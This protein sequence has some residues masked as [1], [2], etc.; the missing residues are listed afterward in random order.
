MW[1]SIARF[2][3]ALF[4]L[5][6]LTF[7]VAQAG[8]GKK[9]PEPNTESSTLSALPASTA[10][11]ILPPEKPRSQEAPSS[12]P[13]PVAL[14]PTFFPGT[15]SGKIFPTP[16]QKPEPPPKKKNKPKNISL[17]APPPVSKANSNDTVLPSSKSGY[18]FQKKQ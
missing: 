18:I 7:V 1:R 17:G 16:A 10:D 9:E 15:K 14:D 11:P 2:C 4:A 6:V 8:C 5:C 12:Q 3:S 13:P